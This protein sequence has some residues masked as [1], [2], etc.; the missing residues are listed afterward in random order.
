MQSMHRSAGDHENRPYTAMIALTALD[1]MI[2][3]LS[4]AA[5]SS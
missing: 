2:C 1:T 4:P 3:H 5:C